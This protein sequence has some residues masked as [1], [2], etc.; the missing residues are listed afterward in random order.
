MVLYSCPHCSKQFSHKNDYNKHQ[1]RKFKCFEKGEHHNYG[2]ALPERFGC[3]LDGL[4]CTID[5]PKSTK[6]RASISLSSQ[7]QYQKN[8]PQKKYEGIHH[9][10][11][12]NKTDILNHQSLDIALL[13]Y[14]K[15]E[16]NSKKS[17]NSD[18]IACNFCNKKLKNRYSLKR[19]LKICPQCPITK[20]DINTIETAIANKMSKNTSTTTPSITNNT[21]NNTQNNTQNINNIFL[22]N[23]AINTPLKEFGK[24]DLQHLTDEIL[25]K[26]IE[27]PQTG[28]LK[29]I[30]QIHFN[31][32]YPQNQNINMTNK[33][34]T[35]VEVFNGKEWEKQD[36]KIA[37]QNMITSKKDIMDDYMEEKTEKN[38]IS[39]FIKD[40]YERF[41]EMLDTYVRESLNHYDDNEKL[42]IARNCQKLYKEV[43]KQVEI[44]LINNLKNK[45]L[46][47]I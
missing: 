40:N 43:F 16:Q 32:N 3:T 11:N 45:K 8:L 26:V 5:P 37:I 15:N 42:R 30:K 20:T 21:I 17:I 34:E 7:K 27:C 39:S 10:H 23:N 28:I 38:L 31:K 9:Y 4:F 14:T 6:K 12:G 47:I 1:N 33:K 35:Y 24:E 22:V 2:N 44:I 19:H 46:E 41:S 25:S 29:L 36:K 18:T 13:P